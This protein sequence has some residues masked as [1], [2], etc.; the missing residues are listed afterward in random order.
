MKE[1]QAAS[2]SCVFATRVPWSKFGTPSSG[3]GN[4]V[5]VPTVQVAINEPQPIVYFVRA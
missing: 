2:P 1:E 5:S 3:T 4:R